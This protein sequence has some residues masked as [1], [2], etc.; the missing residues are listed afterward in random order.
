MCI[1]SWKAA[2]ESRRVDRTLRSNPRAVRTLSP[3]R[4]GATSGV[5]HSNHVENCPHLAHEIVYK[6]PDTDIFYGVFSGCHFGPRRSW[7]EHTTK[8]G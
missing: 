5:S 3:K 8:I 4:N 7:P 6:L 1:P 2:T